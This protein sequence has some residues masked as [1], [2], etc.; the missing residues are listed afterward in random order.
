MRQNKKIIIIGL[1]GGNWQ[2]LEPLIEKGELPTIRKLMQKGAYGTLTSA[3]PCRSGVAITTFFTGKNPCKWG[4]LDFPCYDPDV[5]SYEK[6]REKSQSVWDILGKYG[7]KSAILNMPATYPPTLT[8]GVMVSGFSVSENDQYTYPSDF[9]EKVKGFHSERETFLKLIR[10][11]L[12][13]GRSLEKSKELLD[14]YI[15]NI[16]KRYGLIKNVIKDETFNFS[17]FWID[18]TD[19]AFHEVWGHEKLLLYFFREVDAILRDVADNNPDAN[20]IVISDHGFD[21]SPTHEFYP[22]SWLEKEGYLKLKGC[23]I[24]RWMTKKINSLAVRSVYPFR[25]RRIERFFSVYNRIKNQINKITKRK[26]KETKEFNPQ[27]PNWRLAR[28]NRIESRAIGIDWSKTVATNYDFWGIRI[29]RE[30]LDRDYEELREEIMEKMRGLKDEND[31]K[32]IKNVWKKEEIFSGEDIQKFP[33]LIYIPESRFEPTGFSPFCIT[34][35]KTKEPSFPGDHLTSR[36]GIFFAAGPD[37]KNIGQIKEVNILDLV[38][39][40]LHIFEVPVPEDMDGRVL[41]EIII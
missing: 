11:T 23:R 17:I 1:D 9:K 21:A 40:I 24:Q 26:K 18:E 25:Y 5:I 12:R 22:K 28:D 4:M 10:G 32:I 29:I 35:K 8:V 41:K 39:T 16:K 19:A 38:P 7:H 14:F 13:I 37:I 36:E 33:D 20:I 30:N 3:I 15:K 2:A 6:I 34:R 31:R 27:N